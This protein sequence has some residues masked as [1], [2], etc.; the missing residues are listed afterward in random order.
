MKN[1]RTSS[2]LPKQNQTTNISSQKLSDQTAFFSKQEANH[3]EYLCTKQDNIVKENV[4]D[5]SLKLSKFCRKKRVK[6]ALSQNANDIL[7]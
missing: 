5:K 3:H 6:K 2:I 1:S 7:P 4:I